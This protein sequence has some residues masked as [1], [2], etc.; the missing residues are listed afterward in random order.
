MSSSISSHNATINTAIPPMIPYKNT[1]SSLDSYPYRRAVVFIPSFQRVTDTSAPTISPYD[2]ASINDAPP[3]NQDL[4][5]PSPPP[6]ACPSVSRVPETTVLI[7]FPHDAAILADAPPSDPNP[8]PTKIHPPSLNGHTDW[9]RLH[10][11]PVF[12][13]AGDDGT[14]GFLPRRRHPRQCL[15]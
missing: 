3:A 15:A 1:P 4:Q 8:T 9:H 13:G 10:Y 11:T 7:I 2:T 14:I 5:N 12:E 6:D